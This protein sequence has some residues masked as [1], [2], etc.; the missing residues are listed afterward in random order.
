MHHYL[1]VLT[2]LLRLKNAHKVPKFEPC[3]KDLG[4]LLSD[5]LTLPLK[6]SLELSLGAL[7]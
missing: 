4:S 1:E 2:I 5:L 7:E 3:P 6:L